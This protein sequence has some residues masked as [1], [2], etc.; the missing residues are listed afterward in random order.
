MCFFTLWWKHVPNWNHAILTLLSSH[1]CKSHGQST[2]NWHDISINCENTNQLD[3]YELGQ[4]YLPA[5]GYHMVTTQEVL[6]LHECKVDNTNTTNWRQAV[7]FLPCLRQGQETYMK[8][9]YNRDIWIFSSEVSKSFLILS[10]IQLMLNLE[11]YNEIQWNNSHNRGV[12]GDSLGLISLF[13]NSTNVVAT[14]ISTHKILFF[15]WNK[16]CSYDLLTRNVRT[17][18]NLNSCLPIQGRLLS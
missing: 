5:W 12:L 4:C 1:T 11:S 13:L 17:D 2:P 15:G 9:L 10:I 7:P 16:I 14:L 6:K 3:H 8:P 18:K